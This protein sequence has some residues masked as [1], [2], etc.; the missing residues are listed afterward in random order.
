[1]I[2]IEKVWITD[3]AVYIRTVDGREACENFS[4]YPRLRY[5]TQ[6]QR[7]NY[8]VDSFG[9]HWADIDEDLSFD[10]FFKTKNSSQLYELFM[11]HPEINASA[12]ARRI[13]ISQSLLAQYISGSK[14]PS[15]ERLELIK[16]EIRL[17][18]KELISI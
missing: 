17:I 1:M 11:S 18:G 9:I 12:V 10:G 15:K 14:R 4:D 6:L 7:E 5:A 2:D 13:G 16:D 8:I 3:T